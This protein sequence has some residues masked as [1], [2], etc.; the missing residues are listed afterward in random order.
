MASPSH[1]HAKRFDQVSGFGAA[2]RPLTY[3]SNGRDDQ[4]QPRWIVLPSAT[5]TDEPVVMALIVVRRAATLVGFVLR[6]VARPPEDD[7]SD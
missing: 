2:R 1:V 3:K 5:T 4:H 6:V 7:P